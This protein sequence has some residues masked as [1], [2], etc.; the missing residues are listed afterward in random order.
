MLLLLDEGKRANNSM[1]S[2]SNFVL[3]KC[4][5]VITLGETVKW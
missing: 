2:N 3:V 1:C 5:C 4:E